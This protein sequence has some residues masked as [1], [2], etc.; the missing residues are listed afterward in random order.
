MPNKTKILIL[1]GGA[2]GSFAPLARAL[3]P[4]FP[5]PSGNPGFYTHLPLWMPAYVGMTPDS[6]GNS[7]F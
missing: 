3:R 6:E 1:G 4:S 7:I 2:G 5:P